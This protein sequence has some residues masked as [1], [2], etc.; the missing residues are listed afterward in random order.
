MRN[1]P[2]DDETKKRIKELRAEGLSVTV[3]ARRL[4]VDPSSVYRCLNGTIRVRRVA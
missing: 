3:V 1:K 4:S 2:I